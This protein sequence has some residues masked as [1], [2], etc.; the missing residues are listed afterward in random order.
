M[1]NA[2]IVPAPQPVSLASGGVQ[3]LR[4]LALGD[5]YTVGEGVAR[6]QCWPE[7]LAERWRAQGL[8]IAPVEII[9]ATGWSAAELLAAIRRAAPKP[10]FDRVL[11]AVGVND[12]YRGLDLRVY[13]RQFSRLLDRACTLAGH[14]RDRV[15]VLSIPDWSVTPFAADDARGRPS[16]AAG[17]ARFNRAAAILCMRRGI[18]FI[19]INRS[20]RARGADTEMLAVDG[21]HPSAAM[22]ALWVEAVAAAVPHPNTPR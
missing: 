14:R 7:Q 11:L 5:S 21:L 20:Y 2:A 6:A 9:A 22:Y 1:A 15:Q 18:E 3:P 17:V 16:I 4:L 13:A 8:R 12:Q 19:D 10:P